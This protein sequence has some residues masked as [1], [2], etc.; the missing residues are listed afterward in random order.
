VM[1]VEPDRC[2]MHIFSSVVT[3]SWADGIAVGPA[4]RVR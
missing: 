3:V 4:W 1:R 2:V